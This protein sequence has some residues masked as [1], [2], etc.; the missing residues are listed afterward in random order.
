MSRR[1]AREFI[2]PLLQPPLNKLFVPRPTPDYLP[3]IDRDKNERTYV[4]VNPTSHYLTLLTGDTVKTDE[5][6]EERPSRKTLTAE[7][8]RAHREAVDSALLTWD[9][10]KNEAATEDAFKTIFV[11]RLPYDVAESKLRR[12]FERY[13]PIKTIRLVTDTITGKNSGYA[14]IEYEREKD[15]KA[16]Y[17]EA[18]GMRFDGGR[19]VVVDV[20]RGRTVR[21]WR[22][23]RLGGGLG[24]T[25]VGGKEHNQ[26]FSGRDPR[27]NDVLDSLSRSGQHIPRKRSPSPRRDD[28]RYDRDERRRR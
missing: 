1:E 11:G 17:I 19:R 13:G 18:D 6:V 4:Q 24:K 25:R 15:M 26:R 16:A 3:P 23:R 5:L 12:E 21:G 27:A 28:R 2:S 7:K 20:E 9:P 22:P 10:S 8:R 14:F